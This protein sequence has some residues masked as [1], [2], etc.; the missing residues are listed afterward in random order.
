[1]TKKIVKHLNFSINIFQKLY[2][3]VVSKNDWNIPQ[4]KSHSR[5]IRTHFVKNT[6]TQ[7]V[8]FMMARHWWVQKIR[9]NFQHTIFYELNT[10]FNSRKYNECHDFDI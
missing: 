1:M 6:P 5:P 9:L 10:L 7:K 8:E 2:G 3:A 4:W